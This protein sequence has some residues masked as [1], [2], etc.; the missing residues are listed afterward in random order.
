MGEAIASGLAALLTP[1]AVLF[2]LV[3]VVYGLI[4]GI[5]PGL[6]GVV[7]M[8][9]LLPFTYGFEK[10]AT[11]SLLLGAHIATVWGDPALGTPT[12]SVTFLDDQTELGTVPL[13]DVPLSDTQSATLT[14]TTLSVG[15]HQIRAYYGGDGVFWSSGSV[16]RTVTI[17]AVTR[18]TIAGSLNPATHGQEVTFT[19]TVNVVSPSTEVPTGGVTFVDGAT[20][21]GTAPLDGNRR[22]TMTTS[23]LRSGAHVIVARYGGDDTFIGSVGVVSQ[24]IGRAAT[25]TRFERCNPSNSESSSW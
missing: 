22:A 5:L 18:T 3:G 21:L 15:T 16:A 7:A 13:S 20:V 4:I 23:A 9:L 6:G 12:G 11:L 24:T 17:K 8:A 2:M 10:A 1:Q 19:A 25:I 14:V